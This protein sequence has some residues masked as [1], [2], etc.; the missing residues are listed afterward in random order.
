MRKL[1]MIRHKP[2]GQ[3]KTAGADAR[4]TSFGKL[5]DKIGNLKNHLR[6]YDDP[7]FGATLCDRINHTWKFR[8]FPVEECEMVEVVLQEVHKQSLKEL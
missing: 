6:M 2:T 3:M 8:N 4:F 7:R 1:Y 5:W